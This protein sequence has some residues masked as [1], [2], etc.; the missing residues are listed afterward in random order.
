MPALNGAQLHAGYPTPSP[1]AKKNG[2]QFN[3]GYG[4]VTPS[5]TIAKKRPEHE[6][7]PSHWPTPPYEENEWASAAAASIFAAGSIYR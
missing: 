1:S 6:H 2:V 7:A 4:N 5:V 3:Q